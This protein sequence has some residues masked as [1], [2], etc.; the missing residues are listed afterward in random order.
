MAARG[1]GAPSSASTGTTNSAR[2]PEQEFTTEGVLRP[3]VKFEVAIEGR[4]VHRGWTFQLNGRID[5]LIGDTLREIKSVMRPLPPRRNPNC[6]P[7]TRNISASSQPTPSCCAPRRD[8][9]VAGR[10]KSRGTC[11]PNSFLSRPVPGLAPDDRPQ[12]CS[13]EA[14][15]F[16][17]LDAIVEFLNL[18]LRATERRRALQFRPAFAS[19]RS[20]QE[21]IQAELGA[22]IFTAL[23]NI[24]NSSGRRAHFAF[25]APTG[26]GKTGCVLEFALGQ[27]RGGRFARMILAHWKIHRATVGC[28]NPSVSE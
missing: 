9:S 15:V 24:G 23:P 26:Y 18:R 7:I 28:P 20:G 4:L 13:D 14:L 25:E 8:P 11:G 22:S 27:M 5:Q 1:F 21:N 10:H 16:H 17:Q 2:G 3:D 6:A 12:P 19:L